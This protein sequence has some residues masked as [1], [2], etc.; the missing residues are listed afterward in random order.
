MHHDGSF[1]KYMELKVIKLREQFD[2]A[3]LQNPDA[4]SDIFRGISI[5]VNGLTRPTH[6]ELKQLMALH[7]GRFENYL[8]R[9]SVTHIICS[10]LPDTKIK[11]LA[12]E[13]RVE[14]MH[15]LAWVF[16]RAKPIPIVRPEWVVASIAAGRLLPIS[17]FQ[18][19]P[20]SVVAPNQRRL[21]EFRK[22][23]APT[24]AP[25]E[26]YPV[27]A[28]AKAAEKEQ[29]QQAAPGG[30]LLAADVR[31]PPLAAAPAA[32]PVP[33][34]VPVHSPSAASPQ[35]PSP[36]ASGAAG[37]PEGQLG[38]SPPLAAAQPGP[39][40]PGVTGR[41]SSRSPGTGGADPAQ[42]VAAELRAASDLA[43]GPPRSTRTDPRFMETF[44]RSSRLHFIG[45]WRT[46]IEA[47]MSE[48]EPHAPAPAPYT[49]GG[50]E[51]VILHVD[52]D[53]FF[54]SVAALGRP[55][56][57]GRPLA[58]CHS[59][60]SRG[61]G[62]VSSANYLARAAGVGADMFIAEAKRR[63]P[64]L[65][66][67]PYEF[68]KYQTVSEQ[69]YRIL[70]SYTS[71]VQPISCDEAFLDVTGLDSDPEALAARLRS[72]IA[73]TTGC[74]ASAGI[75]PNMLVARLATKRAKPNGQFRVTLGSVLDFMADLKID[76]LPGVGWSLATKLEGLGI[77][78]VRQVWASSRAVLQRSLGARTGDDLW[79]HAH[80]RD[81]RRVEPPKARKSVGAE[82]NYGIRFE[83]GEA[84]RAEA[85]KFLGDLAGEVAARLQTAGVKGRSLTLKVK[86][87]Q[88][89]AP[90]PAKFM[91]HGA[92]DNISR[93]VTLGRFTAD[94]ADLRRE[95]MGLLRALGVPPEELRGLGLTV[96]RLDNDPAS[97]TTKPSAPAP[98]RLQSSQATQPA[99]HR[100]G[101][102]DAEADPTDLPGG[103]L[104]EDAEA[105][106]E[107]WGEAHA[108][109]PVRLHQ[110]GVPA[111]AGQGHNQGPPLCV[112]KGAGGSS[113]ATAAAV[114]AGAH[115]SPADVSE[116]RPGARRALEADAAQPAARRS[117]FGGSATGGAA[118]RGGGRAGG[119]AA[120]SRG[121]T[122]GGGGQALAAS[123]I[124]ISVLAEL[125]PDVRREVEREYGEWVAVVAVPR[126]TAPAAPPPPR[127]QQVAAMPAS[128]AEVDPAV[129]DEL[130]PEL[131]REI[132][133]ALRSTAISGV[134]GGTA[135]AVT[136]TRAAAAAG[137]AAAGPSRAP[138]SAGRGGTAAPGG[139]PPPHGAKNAAVAAT[140]A[141]AG[142]RGAGSVTAAGGRASRGPV[143]TAAGGVVERRGMGG[144]GSGSGSPEVEEVVELTA[145]AALPA[146]AGPQLRIA[147]AA[148]HA[149]SAPSPPPG[150]R[151]P[152]RVRE[153]LLAAVQR[154]CAAAAAGA[155]SRSAP[156]PE[157][158]TEAQGEQYQSRAEVTAA[159]GQTA[160]GEGLERRIGATF[161]ALAL[162]LMGQDQD[163]EGIVLTLRR[164]RR[165]AA[166]A[167]AAAGPA[168][169]A[170]GQAAGGTGAAR[171]AGT[172][173][174]V[175]AAML[176]HCQR[177]VR[178]VRE[179]VRH[180]FGFL[181]KV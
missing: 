175:A 171:P 101:A 173:A 159:G 143:A 50:P 144:G 165:V 92:C 7:G 127:R 158:G 43:R 107:G 133:A 71:I 110:A 38:P 106:G 18:L 179:H 61:T 62:E 10:N 29:Q 58:V 40:P 15:G 160:V 176:S 118:A 156:Q 48:V 91:G 78:T 177:A 1:G 153:A 108:P 162:W 166:A 54:A 164:V 147:A 77:T 167:A 129:L 89:G 132:T 96:S 23:A 75:G 170:E 41:A 142:G 181:L 68:D 8:Y 57:A 172:A 35:P 30:G 80:G 81:E 120:A 21:F 73:R 134:A 163:L 11:Q 138:V 24:L 70:M 135:A 45:T 14:A 119:G 47:L 174:P 124:D 12:H 117:L 122:G 149:F 169:G 42:A 9:D 83:S 66:V 114:S 88:A 145:L 152:E 104:A 36:G 98:A 55:E 5:Y 90:Q 86:R 2:A 102:D 53:C 180:K 28:D 72:E 123:Q 22:H 94:A 105:V 103:G 109:S 115:P 112:G 39:S 17:D 74:T 100:P 52:M 27:L 168:G 33:Q 121:R 140:V 93:S 13:R 82:V 67:M 64:D 3:Q 137:A 151:S 46:R 128:L 125:P 155:A 63:C 4:K 146:D 157:T 34:S 31:Q 32:A 97:H 99:A 69:V 26:M 136:A 65:V 111:A 25:S 161:M 148:S 95:A 85:D 141:A 154:A 130:P 150:N 76:Q 131:R 16:G 44:F 49:K 60:S 56:L 79:A 51:R 87:R 20:L 178:A 37:R 113:A 116:G 84:G 59:N 6:A 126:A 139:M 19:E